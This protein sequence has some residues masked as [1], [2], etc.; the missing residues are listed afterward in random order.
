MLADVQYANTNNRDNYHKT[1]MRYYRTAIDRLKDAVKSWNENKVD[2]GVQLGDLIDGFSHREGNRDTDISKLLDALA[3]FNSVGLPVTKNHRKG[4]KF[5]DDPEDAVPYICN[6]WGN[7]EFYNFSREWLCNSPLYSFINEQ[8]SIDV[9]ELD[10]I[11]EYYY[12][13]VYKQ[14]RMIA[15]D[16][17]DI[18]VTGRSPGTE[19]YEHAEKLLRSNNKNI[20]NNHGFNDPDKTAPQYVAYNGGLGNKQLSWL[21]TELANASFLKQKVILFS[22]NPIHPRSSKQAMVCWNYLDLLQ[23]I[24]G[25][26]CV[27]ACFAGHDHDGG[28]YHDTVHNVYY[29]TFEGIIERSESANAFAIID[30]YEDHLHI[31]GYGITK[32]RVLTFHK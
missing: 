19:K 20:K 14:Y 4:Y 32:S 29:V 22:H 23:I 3:G 27:V 1:Q 6:I 13:F 5:V 12:S 10:S 2:F 7:H 18:S 31:H 24:N 30:A 8:N 15:L 25:F 9:R 28:F 26:D 17:Y 21:R 11:D 16:V